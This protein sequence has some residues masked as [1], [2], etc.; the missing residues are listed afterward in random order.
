MEDMAALDAVYDE[1]NRCVAAMS[2]MAQLLRWPCGLG[3]HS[4]QDA[5]WDREW[6]NIVFIDL[7]TGQASWHIHDRDLRLFA[8]LPPYTKQW[9]GHSTAEKYDRLE[10]IY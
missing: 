1:R 5:T 10:R 2:V 8:H 4:E 3:K 7:P 9:D 6:M